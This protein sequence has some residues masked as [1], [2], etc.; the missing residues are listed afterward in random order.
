M[1]LEC[2]VSAES[3]KTQ[4]ESEL[5][6]LK[7]VITG[8]FASG[9]PKGL[10]I[11][12]TLKDLY[13]DGRNPIF[14][15]KANETFYAPGGT[16]REL[17][18]KRFETLT[19]LLSSLLC[20]KLGNN[21]VGG[22]GEM[23]QPAKD[24]AARA[25]LDFDELCLSDGKQEVTFLPEVQ[26]FDK[27]RRFG[28]LWCRASVKGPLGLKS[29]SELRLKRNSELWTNC[30]IFQSLPLSGVNFFSFE[31]NLLQNH[32]KAPRPSHPR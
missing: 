21:V 13:K 28:N 4:G 6:W 8:P 15:A 10:S 27:P 5:S 2:L 32:V 26:I 19:H 18:Q 24:A 25:V 22:W 14:P 11:E 9:V 23:S 7:R 16:E 29:M 17:I 20:F 30:C 12:A 3:P 31:M 1:A